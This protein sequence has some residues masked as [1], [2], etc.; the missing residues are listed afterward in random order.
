M[1]RLI[2]DQQEQTPLLLLPMSKFVVEV[3][4]CDIDDQELGAA[5]KHMVGVGVPDA[6]PLTLLGSG[7]AAVPGA[8]IN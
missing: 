1:R 2:V 6:E 5:I 8:G 7:A 3:R 4:R